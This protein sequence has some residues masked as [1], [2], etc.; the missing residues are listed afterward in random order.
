MQALALAIF[1]SLR[2]YNITLIPIWVSREHEIITWADLGSRDFCS[3]DY[4]L[5]PVTF[6]SLESTY[7]KFTVDAMAN[8]ANSV[9]DKF[10][11]RYSSPGTS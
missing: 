1:L 6:T 11:S 4:S 7:G 9:C 2:K 3:D 8:S 10:F 5:D